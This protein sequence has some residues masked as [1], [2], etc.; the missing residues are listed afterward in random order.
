VSAPAGSEQ[1]SQFA[2]FVEQ[3]LAEEYSR[4]ESVTTRA[5]VAITTSTGLVTVV[6]AV[7][8]VVKGKDFTLKGWPLGTLVVALI[9]LLGAAVLAVTANMP[10]KAYKVAAIDDLRKLLDS[11]WK[12]TETDARSAV[13]QA[14]IR[15]IET[16]RKSTPTRFRWLLASA[17][18]QVGAVVFLG[19][20]AVTVVVQ[21]E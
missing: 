21:Q 18:C 4:R 12:D 6:R 1:G 7:I 19:I 17:W 14:R 11:H 10:W 20:T 8:A 5:S 9:F 13:A 16:L 2:A 3:E 15:T